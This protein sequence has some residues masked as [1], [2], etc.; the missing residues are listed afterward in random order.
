MGG[1]EFLDDSGFDDQGS[2]PLEDV[3]EGMGSNTSDH[4]VSRCIQSSYFPKSMEKSCCIGHYVFCHSSKDDLGPATVRHSRVCQIEALYCKCS[5]GRARSIHEQQINSPHDCCRCQSCPSP[6]CDNRK[7][8]HGILGPWID[9][10]S[11]VHLRNM[12]AKVRD[13]VATTSANFFANFD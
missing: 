7:L 3:L 4:S 10:S 5:S 6:G 12:S 8:A 11:G 2:K 1:G 13:A 9:R